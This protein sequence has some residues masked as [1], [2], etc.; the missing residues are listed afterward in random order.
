ML[1]RRWS[2]KSKN[3]AK[4]MPIPHANQV[5]AQV[6]ESVALAMSRGRMLRMLVEFE[7]WL[8]DDEGLTFN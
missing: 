8:A 5:L 2:G 6:G 3:A 1:L 4:K 7:E